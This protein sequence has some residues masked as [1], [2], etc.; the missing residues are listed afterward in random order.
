[1]TSTVIGSGLI[2]PP[3]PPDAA[4]RRPRPARAA[5]AAASS[6]C[7]PQAQRP[8]LARGAP[9]A[10]GHDGRGVVFLHDRRAG[11]LVPWNE[12]LPAEHRHLAPLPAEVRA[13]P[14]LRAVRG[15]RG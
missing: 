4:G 2:A 6:G 1:M 14:R 13:A 9:P 10:G 15:A 7:P 8:G 3:S 12:S 11:D 5:P